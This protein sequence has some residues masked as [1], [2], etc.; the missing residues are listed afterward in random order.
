VEQKLRVVNM[1]EILIPFFFTQ[2]VRII[3][4]MALTKHMMTISSKQNS[5]RIKMV[6]FIEIVILVIILKNQ[7]ENL[8]SKRG[9]ISLKAGKR[10]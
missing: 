9:S 10:G 6:A 7:Y 1:L 2:K 8:K 3:H 4:G 5:S